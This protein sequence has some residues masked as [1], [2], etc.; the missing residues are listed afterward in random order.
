LIIRPSSLGDVIRT[1]PALVSLRRAFPD[2]RIDWLVNDNLSTAVEHH[3]DLAGVI[4]FPRAALGQ[5]LRRGNIAAF[6]SW[7]KAT[8]GSANYGLVVD[9]QGLFRSGLLTRAT[10][11]VQ[12]IGFAD[13]REVGWLWRP[14]AYTRRVAVPGGRRAHHVDRVLALTAAAGAEPV[15]DLRIYPDPKDKDALARDPQLGGKRYVLLAPTTRGLGRAWPIER[16]A[17]LATRLMSR[18]RELRIDAIVTT[19]LAS[20]R[21]YCRRLLAHLHLRCPEHVDRI[22]KTSISGLMALVEGS[23]LVVCNDSAAMHMAVA[24][25][26]PM[27]AL[28]GAT[29]IGHAGPYKR[30]Q[31]VITHKRPDERV[32]HR[33]MAKASELMRR[34]GVEEVVAGCEQRL[35]REQANWAGDRSDVPGG[36]PV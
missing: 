32:R 29:D 35:R 10:H 6:L 33:D 15:A 14:L 25:G 5:S 36:S 12:R 31:D 13:A 8:L 21:D 16:F 26:R 24:F 20:E 28:F 2:A 17:D 3:P 18:R 22:G 27:V 11:A 19:G 34:I 7:A 23:A 4:P 30:E 1:V 9:Y